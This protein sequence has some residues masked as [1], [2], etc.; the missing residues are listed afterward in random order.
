M[1]ISSVWKE[2]RSIGHEEGG[3]GFELIAW[4]GDPSSNEETRVI[5][6]ED[7][8]NRFVTTEPNADSEQP[9]VNSSSKIELL[10]GEHPMSGNETR[11][12]FC[13][14]IYRSLRRCPGISI[15]V[16]S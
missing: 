10:I 11:T 8:N 4:N 14:V 2:R 9:H 7:V 16:E 6:S 13:Y 15:P 5:D 1:L 3:G 12:V